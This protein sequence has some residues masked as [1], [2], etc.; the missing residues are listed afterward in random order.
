M[1][2]ISST[3]AKGFGS[4]TV[5]A[6]AVPIASVTGL[7]AEQIAQC[8]RAR[9]TCLTNPIVLRYDDNASGIA[10]GIGH[11]L[12]VGQSVEILDQWNIQRLHF[13]RAT[14]VDGAVVV[15]LEG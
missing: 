9:I 2:I 4:V 13:L 6:A 8:S 1:P 15:T 11:S 5:G 14:G 7:T 12:A 10:G 3:T